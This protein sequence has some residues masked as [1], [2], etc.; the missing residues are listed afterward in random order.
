[1]TQMS[2]VCDFEVRAFGCQIQ[3]ATTSPEASAILNRY[4][5]PSFPRTAGGNRSDVSIC[6][7]REAG[8]FQ[9]VV[10]DA[11]VASDTQPIGLVPDLVRVVDEAV[12]QRLTTLRA[13]HAGAVLWDGRVLLLPGATHAG[14]SS[15]VAELLRRGATYYSD[16][17]ALIDAEGRAHPYPRPL[18]LRNGSPTQVPML[19]EECNAQVG[20]SAAPIGWILA[21][22]YM[23]DSPWS[24]SAI[25]Q[26][27]ALVVLL[28]N[29]PHFLAETPEMLQSFQR[30]VAGTA[31]YIGCQSNVPQAAD[32]ILKIIGIP[33]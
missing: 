8:H 3:V 17:Y 9:L 20:D 32:E 6:I 33:V 2:D 5:F 1:L 18:L 16:E 30:A 26:S 23:P 27:E 7:T 10:D 12:I 11:L 31:S 13:V 15:L 21:L 28:Q 14:K 24:V 19:P 29:T 25:C 4:I 22:R